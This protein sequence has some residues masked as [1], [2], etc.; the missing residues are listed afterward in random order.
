MSI[1]IKP[2]SLTP[3]S[4]L[5]KKGIYTLTNQYRNK[6]LTEKGDSAIEFDPKSEL[7]FTVKLKIGEMSQSKDPNDL[8]QMSKVKIDDKSREELIKTTKNRILILEQRIKSEK[9]SEIALTKAKLSLERRKNFLEKLK[10]KNRQITENTN[11]SYIGKS[12]QKDLEKIVDIN[13]NH[14]D[15]QRLD[16]WFELYDYLRS[17]TLKYIWERKIQYI[18]TLE[19]LQEEFKTSYTDDQLPNWFKEFFDGLKGNVEN[20]VNKKIEKGQELNSKYIRSF[21]DEASEHI[22]NQRG[23]EIFHNYVKHCYWEMIGFDTNLGIET[24]SQVKA[25]TLEFIQKNKPEL[26]AKSIFAH[27]FLANLY[28]DLAGGIAGYYQ[29]FLSASIKFNY[30]KTHI[31]KETKLNNLAYLCREIFSIATPSILK[32]EV[33]SMREPIKKQNAQ[34]ALILYTSVFIK[35]QENLTIQNHDM[36]IREATTTFNGIQE[37]LK[38]SRDSNVK[39]LQTKFTD[40]SRMCNFTSIS[41]KRIPKLGFTLRDSFPKYEPPETLEQLL[42]QVNDLKNRIKAESNKSSSFKQAQKNARSS[43]IFNGK[44]GRKDGSTVNKNELL[45]FQAKARFF[46][47]ENKSDHLVVTAQNEFFKQYDFEIVELRKELETLKAD[48]N[49]EKGGEVLRKYADLLVTELKWELLSL[50]DFQ[51]RSELYYAEIS[52]LASKVAG[53]WRTFEPRNQSLS[54]YLSDFYL[55]PERSHA[56][57]IKDTHNKLSILFDFENCLTNIDVDNDYKGLTYT[58][59]GDVNELLK[60]PSVLTKLES[61]QHAKDD[62]KNGYFNHKLWNQV[63]PDK[64]REFNTAKWGG[65]KAQENSASSF[66]FPLQFGKNQSR[67]YFNNRFHPELDIFKEKSRLKCSS[68]RLHKQFNPLSQTWEYFANLSLYRLEKITSS[69][70]LDNQN[71]ITNCDLGSYQL[72]TLTKTNAKTGEIIVDS[73]QSAVENLQLTAPQFRLSETILRLENEKQL[74]QKQEKTSYLPPEKRKNLGNKLRSGAKQIQAKLIKLTINEQT[75]IVVENGIDHFKLIDADDFAKKTM[76]NGKR[77]F[78][79]VESKYQTIFPNSDQVI[80]KVPEDSTSKICINCGFKPNLN[81]MDIGNK[82]SKMN[83]EDL[84]HLD[85]RNL[86]GITNEPAL[87]I[88]KKNRNLFIVD[89]VESDPNKC[90]IFISTRDTGKIVFLSENLTENIL[91]KPEGARTP[92]DISVLKNGLTYKHAIKLLVKAGSGEVTDQTKPAWK[93]LIES[94]VICSPTWADKRI[95]KDKERRIHRVNRCLNCGLVLKSKAGEPNLLELQGS[96]NIGRRFTFGGGFETGDKHTQNEKFSQWYVEKISEDGKP[97][98]SYSKWTE[99]IKHY[100]K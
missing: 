63:E 90:M 16:Q 22:K 85:L 28:D 80:Y 60:N 2:S 61:I 78:E 54:I 93:R 68:I 92:D 77:F 39:S 86:V 3:L 71:Y 8:I 31:N 6:L 33:D 19:K 52:D 46:L 20:K 66:L 45:T 18:E 64:F 53:C 95:A 48:R 40:S 15:L 7:V 59:S 72:V 44:I 58:Y 23:N 79:M 30:L 88:T 4:K 17:Q 96:I 69:L 10:D 62:T 57:L 100:L 27:T 34:K 49:P 47:K 43:S 26:D 70:D 81:I 65:V 74:Y 50:N 98:S 29:K 37:L 91:R 9:L 83:P 89:L 73:N 76:M 11:R 51:G 55:R 82:L 35:I 87:P 12:S 14:K 36:L 84:S 99:N 21:S 5:E 42:D 1:P 13:Q 56:K 25:K 32:N 24:S 94:L 97:F 67:K 38:N 75:R 41:L